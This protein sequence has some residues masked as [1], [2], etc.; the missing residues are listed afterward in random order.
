MYYL[1]TKNRQLNTG[2]LF[3][4]ICNVLLLTQNFCTYF[5][6]YR[7]HRNFFL[8]IFSGII[9]WLSNYSSDKPRCQENLN[10]VKGNGHPKTTKYLALQ[11]FRFIEQS[12]LQPS[13][14]SPAPCTLFWPYTPWWEHFRR[15]P[16]RC[17][18]N[19]GK[20]SALQVS[21]RNKKRDQT[22]PS[23]RVASKVRRAINHFVPAR[24]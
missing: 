18:T 3:C 7:S 2:S 23:H 16:L 15:F 20:E 1:I 22:F 12:I 14:T 5:W 6:R 24:F 19:A 4:P 13:F 17:E 21:D 10:C 8:F 9:A 11:K